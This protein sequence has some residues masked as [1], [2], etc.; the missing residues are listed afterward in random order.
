MEIG[1]YDRTRVG[2]RHVVILCR[3]GVHIFS[4]YLQTAQGRSDLDKEVLR[5]LARLVKMAKRA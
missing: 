5:L 4:V 1:E 2:G 3:G